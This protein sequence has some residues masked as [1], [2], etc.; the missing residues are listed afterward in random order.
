MEENKIYCSH[1]G[2]L[3][4][5]DEDY[6]EVNGEIV[7][8]DCYENHTTTCDRCG[9]VIVYLLQCLFS[10]LVTLELKQV[11]EVFGNNSAIDAP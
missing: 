10:T 6:E 3:I 5:D 7:C 11:Y 1:C 8:T 4:E 2:A 9:S